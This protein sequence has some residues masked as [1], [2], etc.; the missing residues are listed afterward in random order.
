[1]EEVG[2][3][4]F[5]KSS[6]A[7]RQNKLYNGFGFQRYCC[8]FVKKD[9]KP[10]KAVPHYLT[11]KFRSSGKARVYEDGLIAGYCLTHMYMCIGTNLNDSE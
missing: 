10:C 9:G 1:M 4:N 7:W 8:G 11:K 5:D 6:V 2:E 3:L